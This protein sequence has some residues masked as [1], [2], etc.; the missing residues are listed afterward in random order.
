VPS[1]SDIVGVPALPPASVTGAAD[2]M[3]A[4]IGRVH[5]GLAPPPVRILEG[6]FG[7]LDYA[8]L[9]A[10]CS[11]DVPD[12][13]DRRVDLA[14]LADRTGADPERL[15][16]VVR[17][18][19]GRGWLAIDRRGRVAPTR[20][21]RFLRRDHPGGWRAWVD[22]ATGAEVLAAVGAL[23]RDPQD[24][25][26]FARANAAPFFEWYAARPERHRA[27]DDAMAAGG[28][29]HGI[30]LAAAI[31]WRD[32]SRVCDVGGGS[33]AL[34]RVLLDEH[35]HLAG[36]VLDL[37]EVVGRA[38]AGD[39]LELRGG[40]AFR[41]AVPGCDVYLF[42]NVLHDWPDDRA[43]ELLERVRGAA[44]PGARVVVVEGE[45]RTRPRDGVALRSDLLMLALTPGGRER[46][47]AEIAALAAAA[48]FTLQRSVAL[49]SG[50]QAHVLG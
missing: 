8:A 12:R 14:T 31:D 43:T 48:G 4:M 11:L 6:L 38:E 3:R 1:L 41:D 23:T 50:D 13:L 47:T 10:L 25:D 22:F 21:T 16:R 9:G 26:P 2:R 20:T 44:A 19:A 49:A 46:T 28:R 15:E 29:L 40:D 36:V 18:A 34:L 5:Q 37:P 35:P 45:R 39:R 42:V 27:F 17:Y 7:V 33:G 32:A 30:A 24:P